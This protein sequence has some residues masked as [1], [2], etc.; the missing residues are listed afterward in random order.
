[1]PERLDD[2]L[3]RFND[4]LEIHISAAWWRRLDRFNRTVWVAWVV[5]FAFAGAA[6]AGWA[7]AQGPW[8]VV[9]A[10]PVATG[11]YLVLRDAR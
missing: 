8:G 2:W 6:I 10:I 3:K 5:L 1:V 11:A 7:L 4:W 9:F